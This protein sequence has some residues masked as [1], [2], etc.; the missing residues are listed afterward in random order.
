LE[1]D[2]ILDWTRKGSIKAEG[3][4]GLIDAYYATD[5][6]GAKHEIFICPYHK[7]NSV[8]APKGFYLVQ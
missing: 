3:V 4:E 7:K 5:L 2:E 6:S 8:K 1:N